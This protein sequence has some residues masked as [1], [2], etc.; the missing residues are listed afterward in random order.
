M[1]LR[2]H[3]EMRNDRAHAILGNTCEI[4]ASAAV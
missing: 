4:A 1:G 3:R 2:R